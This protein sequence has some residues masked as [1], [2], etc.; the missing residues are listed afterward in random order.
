MASNFADEQ[1]Y[2]TRNRRKTTSRQFVLAKS[3]SVD[4]VKQKVQNC[5]PDMR[6][7]V[8]SKGS[9]EHFYR[10]FRRRGDIILTE[11]MVFH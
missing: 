1:P 10:G 6:R 11:N 7:K 8:F 9:H 3:C 5:N 4:N 2:T